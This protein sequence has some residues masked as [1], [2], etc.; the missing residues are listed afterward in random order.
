MVLERLSWRVACPNHA[1]FLLVTVARRSHCGPRRNLTL[2][3]TQSLVLCSKYEIRRSFL[4]HLISKDWLLYG[5]ETWTLAADSGKKRS[6]FKN[7]TKKPRFLT[8]SCP[9]MLTETTSDPRPAINCT[10]PQGQAI[11]SVA[12]FQDW[13]RSWR[14]KRTNALRVSSSL[15]SG[16][17]VEKKVRRSFSVMPLGQ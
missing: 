13:R 10:V 2:L 5:C 7:K 12:S 4:M 17:V 9:S 1:G 6:I 8:N 15:G 14:R 11:Q 16:H 3:H